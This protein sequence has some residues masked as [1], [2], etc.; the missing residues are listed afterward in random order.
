MKSFQSF[1]QGAGRTLT[2]EVFDQLLQL[3]FFLERLLE[4]GRE[5]GLN[6]IEFPTGGPES[7]LR[8]ALGRDQ[9]AATFLEVLQ[10]DKPLPWGGPVLGES[11]IDAVSDFWIKNRL[12]RFREPGK[13]RIALIHEHTSFSPINISRLLPSG[14]KT[15]LEAAITSWDGVE[16]VARRSADTT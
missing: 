15:A 12:A 14:A 7:K 3:L 16:L 2:H 4:L 10:F 13:S 11:P 8:Y 6:L 9:N 1:R 5:F